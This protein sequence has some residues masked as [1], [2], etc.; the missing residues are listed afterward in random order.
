MDDDDDGL[1]DDD[2][3]DDQE[4]E[5][6][7]IFLDKY[8]SHI[9]KM[10]KDEPMQENFVPLRESCHAVFTSIQQTLGTMDFRTILHEAFIAA[11]DPEYGV[12][13]TPEVLYEVVRLGRALTFWTQDL[14]EDGIARI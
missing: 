10:L 8:C 4:F 13:V 9:E 6:D 1:L 3:M 14:P 2:D 12:V 7:M 5:M 11:T